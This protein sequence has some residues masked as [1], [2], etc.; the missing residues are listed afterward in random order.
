M[1][2]PASQL[3]AESLARDMEAVTLRRYD[4]LHGLLC[5]LEPRR[6]Q[7]ISGIIS[8]LRERTVDSA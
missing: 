4:A 7:I 2:G 6:S 5:E 8:W 3:A 1:L